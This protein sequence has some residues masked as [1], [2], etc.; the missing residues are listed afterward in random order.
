[1][2][3]GSLGG[4]VMIMLLEAAADKAGR[5]AQLLRLLAGIGMEPTDSLDYRFTAKID[6]NGFIPTQRIEE[7]GSFTL[8]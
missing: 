7:T 1:M 6:F 3:P 2:F 4:A 5:G 8:Q